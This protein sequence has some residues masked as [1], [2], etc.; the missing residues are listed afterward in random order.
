LLP[1]VVNPHLPISSFR[2]A[3]IAHLQP[4]S[5]NVDPL[6]RYRSL[7]WVGILMS[8]FALPGLGAFDQYLGNWQWAEGEPLYD[9]DQDRVKCLEAA[10]RGE[11][12]YAYS[13]AK[14]LLATRTG[15]KVA[16]Q[17]YQWMCRAGDLQ[18]VAARYYCG[19]MLLAGEGTESDPRQ[20]M[21][22]IEEAAARGFAKAALQT[23]IS[24]L[25][26]RGVVQ[27]SGQAV[28]WLRQ[29][30]QREHPHA[31]YLLGA[32]YLQGLGVPADSSRALAYFSQ[33]AQ[34]GHADAQ[35]QAAILYRSAAE[36]VPEL[37]SKSVELMR[38]AADQ[39]H[40]RAMT[41]LAYFYSQGV[42]V[43]KDNA[44]AFSLNTRAA[45]A[46]YPPGQFNLAVQYYKGD[47]VPRDLDKSLFWCRKAAGAGDES[48][49]FMLGELYENG[50]GVSQ[51]LEM[52]VYWYAKA[53]DN[54]HPLAMEALQRVAEQKRTK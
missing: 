18:H 40:P 48:A 31:L 38:Q 8:A 16:E 52:A 33:A 42:G 5:N 36:E 9:C 7:F 10:K 35:L 17:A 50:D 24:Y 22:M 37:M 21:G 45:G 39:G 25:K 43:D 19:A 27:D 46:G 44:Q 11:A 53:A 15:E 6:R 54:R 32:A 4:P 1:F 28:F 12:E 29:A 14:S 2:K 30:A 34:L 51:D 3:K 20:G 13:L 41:A 47:G 26:G 49:Q 23:G